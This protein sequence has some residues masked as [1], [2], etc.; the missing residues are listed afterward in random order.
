MNSFLKFPFFFKQ[1]ICLQA[2]NSNP[3]QFLEIHDRWVSLEFYSLRICG[4]AWTL[5]SAEIICSAWGKYNIGC[6]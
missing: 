6:N 4:Y 1:T 2:S 5:F 3:A